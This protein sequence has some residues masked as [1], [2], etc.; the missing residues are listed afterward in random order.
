MIRVNVKNFSFAC[1]GMLIL[2]LMYILWE[3]D[4]INIRNL[5]LLIVFFM[6]TI[7][8]FVIKNFSISNLIKIRVAT[9]LYWTVG[10]YF[11][12]LYFILFK[13][14]DIVDVNFLFAI[15]IASVGILSF[16]CGSSLSFKIVNIYQK[17]SRVGGM[18]TN[19]SVLFLSVLILFIVTTITRVLF[20][21]LGI[22]SPLFSGL[23]ESLPID[24]GVYNILMPFLSIHYLIIPVI[25]WLFFSN[26]NKKQKMILVLIYLVEL[27]FS[28]FSF[29]RLPVIYGLFI[30][31]LVGRLVNKINLKYI[32]LILL[33]SLIILF[34]VNQKFRVYIL[35]ISGYKYDLQLNFVD[36]IKMFTNLKDYIELTSE[37]LLEIL[38]PFFNRFFDNTFT[39]LLAIIESKKELKLGVTYLLFL[40]NFIPR[41]IWSDKPVF[42]ISYDFGIEYGIISPNE[43]VAITVSRIGEAYMNFGIIGVIIILFIWGIIARL[44]E[45]SLLKRTLWLYLYFYVNFVLIAETFF[46]NVFAI[47]FKQLI[48]FALVL[49]LSLLVINSLNKFTQRGVLK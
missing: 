21:K 19:T 42:Q 7:I 25:S 44:I 33:I 24:L 47:M 13:E 1:L 23:S 38:D 39:N 17:K 9:L 37:D 3:I 2:G 18:V 32:Y 41:F 49:I 35:A 46:T 16:I 6:I 28:F 40:Y 27:F 5:V 43:T 10:Y 36:I 26:I 8:V 30:P 11:T 4:I 29:Q 22:Y 31:I 34:Y 20:L 12:S 45:Q 15:I 14:E 48:Y